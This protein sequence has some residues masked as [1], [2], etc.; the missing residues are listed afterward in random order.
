MCQDVPFSWRDRMP[1]KIPIGAGNAALPHI[2][3]QGGRLIVTYNAE[4]L[5]DFQSALQKQPRTIARALGALIKAKASGTIKRARPQRFTLN[6]QV[7]ADLLERFRVV[8][9]RADYSYDEAIRLVLG[10]YINT[11]QARRITERDADGEILRDPYGNRIRRKPNRDAVKA[12]SLG[13]EAISKFQFDAKIA[14]LK[15]VIEDLIK[16]VGGIDK[17]KFISFLVSEAVQHLETT[18][19][20]LEKGQ[21]M[22]PR[23][24]VSPGKGDAAQL[25]PARGSSTPSEL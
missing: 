19:G 23:C 15:A 20:S 7:P 5:R 10:R 17:S 1:K 4:I 12:I 21:E 16:D 11:K 22:T 3:V 6:A 9:D 14:G 24:L 2:L 25:H 13:A 8:C 18:E